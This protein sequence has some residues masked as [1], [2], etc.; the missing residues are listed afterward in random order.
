MT[1]RVRQGAS[2]AVVLG[3]VVVGGGDKGE[4]KGEIKAKL[5]VFGLC[6]IG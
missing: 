5:L 3:F 6:F 1:V 4:T 2:K